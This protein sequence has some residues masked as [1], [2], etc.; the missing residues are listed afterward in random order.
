MIGRFAQL[1][2]YRELAR[3]R[4]F[5]RVS[6]AGLLALASYVWDGGGEHASPTGIV[7]ALGSLSLNGIPIIMG[8]VKG[9]ARRKVNVDELVSLAIIASLIRG[10]F[11]AAAIVSFVMVL[12]GLI[13][14]VT[15]GSARKAIEALVEIAPDTATVLVDGAAKTVSLGEV[16]AG[17]RLLIKPGERI[18]VDGTVCKGVSAVDESSMTGEP[19]PCAKTT[20]DTVYAGTLNQNGV[21]EV[22][23]AKVGAETT[24]GKVIKLVSEAEAHKPETV[25]VI[26]QYARWF[27][28]A[29]LTCAVL[30]WAYTG[31]ADRAIAVLIVGCPCAL[32]LAAPTAI[33]AAIGR[34]AQSGILVKGG[35]YLEAA[36]QA[37]VILFDKTGT[38]TEGNP[39]IDDIF[40]MEG[41]PTEHLL[42]RAASVEQD[43]T[44][45]LARA[46]LRAAHYAKVRVLE[47]EQMFTE[48]GL[49]VRAMVDG[50][51]VE[52]GNVY[53]GGSMADVS[54]ALRQRIEAFKERGATPLVVYQDKQPLGVLS[55]A[56]PIRPRAKEMVEQ[57]RA[58]G[59]RRL[60]VL[61]GDHEKSARLVAEAIGLDQAWPNLRPQDKLRVIQDFQ[62]AGNVVMFVGDGINDA[63]ALATANVGIAMGAA[64]TDVALETA[65]I[66]LMHDDILKLPFL[67]RLSRRM[68][69]IIKLNIGFGLVF[70]GL[71][72]GASASGALTPI[73]GALV[74]NFGSILVVLVAASLA[75]MREE[76][77]PDNA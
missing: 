15:S 13:E 1:G 32:I 29:I 4:D 38:L 44:H 22:A 63:P 23:A 7:L 34:A 58:L 56:D 70:N 9:L 3:S 35:R 51:L 27:T 66:A 20:G 36:G 26:D 41:I 14:E 31:A 24:L 16:R 72:V 48:I 65:D 52:V 6:L 21:I 17:D 57:L 62:S 64:G 69:K 12:G 37:D 33:V 19:I 40:P 74:H 5:Y 71:A 50:A 46:V 10:D 8:A 2:V 73:K 43:S 18:P 67:I 77:P 45:P 54:P 25:R 39:R 30:V 11:L 59:V 47:A 61:S 76:A 60:G 75:F 42:S 28:P 55:V 68:V 49:G 53:V